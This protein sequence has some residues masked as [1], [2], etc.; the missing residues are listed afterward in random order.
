MPAFFVGKFISDAVMVFT[1]D[2]VATNISSMAQGF[3][4]WQSLL[5]TALGI[6]VIASSF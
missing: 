2:Y 1:G 4:N 6:L 5:G 3:L